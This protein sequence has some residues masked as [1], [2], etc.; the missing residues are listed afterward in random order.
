[1]GFGSGGGVT[2][3]GEVAHPVSTTATKIPAATS[4]LA[5][6]VT[7]RATLPA[8]LDHLSLRITDR[9]MWLLILEALLALGIL[10]FIVWWTWPKKK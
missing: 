7:W 3:V 2:G 9:S 10:L 6:A 1:V 5:T 4:R 8:T